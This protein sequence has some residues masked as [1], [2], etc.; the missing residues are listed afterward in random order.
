M[1]RI[2]P[3]LADGR[4]FTSYLSSSQYN[5]TLKSKFGLQSESQ[6]RQFLQSNAS[7]ALAQTRALT[8]VARV[9]KTADATSLYGA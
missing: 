4:S 7:D 6:Y 3:S 9:A 8:V 2:A 5:E 1:S